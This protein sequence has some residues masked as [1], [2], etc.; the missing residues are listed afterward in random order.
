MDFT[1]YVLGDVS[2]FY[3]TINGVAMIFRSGG[4]MNGVYLVGGFIALISGIMFM[5]QKGGGEQFVP[6]NGPIAG[7]FGFGMVV[8]CCSIQASVTIEDIYTGNIAKVDHV[9]LILAAPASLFTTTSYSVFDKINTA[10][11]STSGSYMGAVA[12]AE[13]NT[14]IELK[15]EHHAA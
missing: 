2:S 13:C 10:F 9:P 12:G 14:V 5:I 8:A 3:S 4:F 1:V 6:A 7:L 11:Q 15:L